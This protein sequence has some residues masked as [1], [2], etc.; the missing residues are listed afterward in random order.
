VQAALDLAADLM[1]ASGAGM[2]EGAALLAELH[3]QHL[4][5]VPIRC[6]GV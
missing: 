2:E 4:A 6:K 5:I 1:T 3:Y